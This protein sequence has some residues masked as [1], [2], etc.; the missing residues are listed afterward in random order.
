MTR[1]LQRLLALTAAIWAQR[2]KWPAPAAIARRVR[3]RLTS[4]N[5]IKTQVSRAATRTSGLIGGI[6]IVPASSL[7]VDSTSVILDP[8]RTAR[9]RVGG[10]ARQ[11]DAGESAGSHV[12]IED[13]AE[14]ADSWGEAARERGRGPIK[15][16]AATP[17]EAT[18]RTKRPWHGGH[19]NDES[20]T[21]TCGTGVRSGFPRFVGC[22]RRD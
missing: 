18:G 4:W 22:E 9:R 17:R 7:L 2:P 14:R 21:R 15:G 5:R 16:R 20:L 12:P 10:A 3:S 19:Y 8:Q 1:V 13:L 11:S 6:Q